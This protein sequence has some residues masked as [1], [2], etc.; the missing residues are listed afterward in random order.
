MWRL[1]GGQT[2]S[3]QERMRGEGLEPVGVNDSFIQRGTRGGSGQ[4]GGNSSSTW[5]ADGNDPVGNKSLV[6]QERWGTR[7]SNVRMW[8]ALGTRVQVEKMAFAQSQ[9]ADP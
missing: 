6:I 7:W 3:V 8:E 2:E 9:T 5:Y 1:F 4:D